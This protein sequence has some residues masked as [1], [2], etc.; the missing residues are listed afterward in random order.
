MVPVTVMSTGWLT[1]LF[2]SIVSTGKVAITMRMNAENRKS[3]IPQ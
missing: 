3:R 2:P 1:V